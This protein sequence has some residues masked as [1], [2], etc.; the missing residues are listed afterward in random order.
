MMMVGSWE[1]FDR[2]IDGEL[3]EFGEAAYDEYLS[4]ILDEAVQIL[5]AGGATVQIATQP[6]PVMPP[7]PTGDTPHEWWKDPEWRFE[8]VNGLLRDLASRHPNTSVLLDLAEMVCPTD[9]CETEVE[10]E[11]ADGTATVEIRPDGIHYGATGGELVADWLTPG[12]NA[13][14]LAQ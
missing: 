14:H 2:R 9:P 7:D 10:I 13:A 12:V 6:V 3:L 5:A 4:A 11:T 1:V 8:H